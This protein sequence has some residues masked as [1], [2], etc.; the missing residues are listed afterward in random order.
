MDRISPRTPRYVLGLFSIC[1]LLTKVPCAQADKTPIT[2]TPTGSTSPLTCGHASP[3]ECLQ[4]DPFDLFSPETE[5]TLQDSFTSVDDSL[6][7][8]VNYVDTFFV[9]DRLDYE[10]RGNRLRV[11]F[12]T[13]LEDREGVEVSPRFRINVRLPRTSNRLNLVVGSFDTDSPNGEQPIMGNNDNDLFAGLR[14]FL[15]GESYLKHLHGLVDLGVRSDGA[16]PALIARTRLRYSESWGDWIARITPL[17]YY[18]TDEKLGSGLG[19]DIDRVFSESLL[20]RNRLELNYSDRSIN[21]KQDVQFIEDLS[22]YVLPED[23]RGYR[24]SFSLQG[25]SRGA[26]T[27]TNYESL[28][29]VRQALFKNLVYL[30]V[31]PGLAW[32]EQHDY[33]T[34]LLARCNLEFIFGGQGGRGIDFMR[35]SNR[36]FLDSGATDGA[37][38]N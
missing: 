24:F 4:D 22:L 9:D 16:S 12:E 14:T 2:A 31:G 28:A 30:E 20:A 38:W 33:T 11:R 13:K 34:S 32:R 7:N 3:E 6:Q 10:T 21:E 15:G 18:R 27:V 19:I 37:Q 5:R 35:K 1:L 29:L 17:A 8:S 25:Q 26:T 23:K 36:D